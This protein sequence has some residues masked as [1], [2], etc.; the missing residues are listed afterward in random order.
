M[1]WLLYHFVLLLSP[2]TQKEIEIR[3]EIVRKKHLELKEAAGKESE[4]A[5]E[6]SSKEANNTRSESARSGENHTVKETINEKGTEEETIPDNNE[7][8]EEETFVA[9]AR[10]FSGTIRKGQK[11]YVLGPKYDPGKGLK[12]DTNEGQAVDFDSINR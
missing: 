5:Q 10:I 12:L 11:L 9:F 6:P 3:R 7:T 2:L 1:C 4:N 8:E